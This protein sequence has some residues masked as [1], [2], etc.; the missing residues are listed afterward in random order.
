VYRAAGE[1]KMTSQKNAPKFETLFPDDLQ[2]YIA[3]HKEGS[4]LLLDVRQPEEFEEYHLPGSQLI[5]LPLLAASLTELDK[6]SDIIVYCAVG[7]RSIMAAQFL[8]VRGFGRVFHLQGGIEAWEDRTASGPIGLQ[9]EFIRGNETAVEAAGIAYRLEAGLE[10]FH[11]TAFERSGNPQVRAL[12]E[13]LIKAEE[14]H[15]LRLRGLLESLGSGPEPAENTDG[16]MEGGVD[17]ESFLSQ[18]EQY[19]ESPR[20]CLELAMMIEVQAL[21]L[22]LRMGQT[23]TDK[24]AKDVF[25]GLADEEKSHLSSL[26]ELLGKEEAEVL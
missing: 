25:F 26:G 16:K 13:R 6:G 4:Y 15:M 18:N 14:S 12:L 19:L 8:A 9:L 10:M 21:D 17:I 3:E 24:A 11:R 5:P 23:C 20:G 22:Y 7:G 2:E 1:V